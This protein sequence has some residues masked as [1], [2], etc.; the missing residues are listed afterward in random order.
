M[1]APGRSNFCAGG[2]SLRSRAIITTS[3]KASP[4]RAG[5]R[6]KSCGPQVNAE[7]RMKNAEWCGMGKGAGKRFPEQLRVKAPPRFH[8][9]LLGGIG[10]AVRNGQAADFQLGGDLFLEWVSVLTRGET[11]VLRENE[12]IEHAA[13][14]RVHEDG[15]LIDVCRIGHVRPIGA[16][17]ESWRIRL[18]LQP[19]ARVVRRPGQG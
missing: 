10:E 19:P 2:H 12:A 8:E 13:I 7:G 4:L 1:L 3:W 9:A 11:P 6:T 14:G 15:Q 18:G 5:S 16:K 17:A